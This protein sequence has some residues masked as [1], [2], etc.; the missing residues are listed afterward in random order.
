MGEVR[1]Y[2]TF[3]SLVIWISSI[4]ARKNANCAGRKNMYEIKASR[5]L[6]WCLKQHQKGDNVIS[7]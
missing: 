3:L 2:R 4:K 5:K 7:L 1:T 6:H